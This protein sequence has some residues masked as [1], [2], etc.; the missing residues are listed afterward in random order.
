MELSQIGAGVYAAEAI[1]RKKIVGKKALYEIKWKGYSTKDNTWEP[2]ENIIDKR[3]LDQF[4]NSFKNQGKVGRGKK[5]LNK[6][7]NAPSTSKVAA[8]STQD[9]DDEEDDTEEIDEKLLSPTD[10]VSSSESS[11]SSTSIDTNV[12][13]STTK[14]EV[15]PC[16]PSTSQ[17]TKVAVNTTLKRRAADANV[18]HEF[19][20]LTKSNKVTKLGNDK[21]KDGKIQATKQKSSITT[22]TN[23]SRP[24]SETSSFPSS[25][26]SLTELSST[27]NNDPSKPKVS[28]TPETKLKIPVDSTTN[29]FGNRTELPQEGNGSEEIDASVPPSTPKQ[30]ESASN[31]PSSTSTPIHHKTMRRSSPPPEVWKKQTKMAD[32]ILI[33]DV[34]SNNMTITVREC[35]TAH[36]FFKDVSPLVR[37]TTNSSVAVTSD[38]KQPN[39]PKVS[40]NGIPA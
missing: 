14:P 16:E 9:H 23:D 20:G 26:Q 10:S 30:P 15:K 32:K 35:S 19:L 37:K 22:S 2:E 28:T 40:N 11:A 36:G 31:G 29:G 25:S 6:S 24:K 33:T 8:D 27:L 18:A 5:P 3:L 38:N 34:T 4:N 1:L 17:T 7:K 39:R 12:Q 13:E 21:N